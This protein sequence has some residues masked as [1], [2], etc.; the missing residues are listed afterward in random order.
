M[1]QGALTAATSSFEQAGLQFMASATN[2]GRSTNPMGTSVAVRD[3]ALVETGQPVDLVRDFVDIRSAR[4][5]VKAGAAVVRAVQESE[6]RL[7]DLL[8]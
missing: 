8:A 7:L 4:I 2:V 5:Q 1:F 6:R 3:G